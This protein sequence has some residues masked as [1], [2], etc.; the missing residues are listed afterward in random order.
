MF[1][2]TTITTK[3]FWGLAF[4]TAPLSPLR[5]HFF[6]SFFYYFFT[7]IFLFT[8]FTDISFLSLFHFYFSYHNSSWI[9]FLFAFQ[10][11][12]GCFWLVSVVHFTSL[13][14]FSFS[15]Y[16]HVLQTGIFQWLDLFLRFDSESVQGP[17]YIRQSPT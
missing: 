16:F 12:L 15:Y 6:F 17:F 10:L 5:K 8:V 4:A 14:A 13:V 3:S 1:T 2:T 7:Y 9:D 11:S